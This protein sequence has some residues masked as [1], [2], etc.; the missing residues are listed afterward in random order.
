MYVGQAGTHW[1]MGKSEFHF[2]QS[3]CVVQGGGVLVLVQQCGTGVI[4]GEDRRWLAQTLAFFCELRGTSLAVAHRQASIQGHMQKGFAG[5]PAT[6]GNM[7]TRRRTAATGSSSAP[8][9]EGSEDRRQLPGQQ[10]ATVTAK[11]NASSLD[12]APGLRPG[13]DM[14]M[15]DA[16]GGEGGNSRVG[17]KAVLEEMAGVRGSGSGGHMYLDL[18]PES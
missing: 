16:L 7:R 9:P 14:D 12:A 17:I 8:I 2:A 4:G 15:V 18:V 5:E 3:D 13:T 6:G 10:F 11:P 1:G